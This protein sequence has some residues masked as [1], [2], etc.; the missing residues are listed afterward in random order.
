MARVKVTLITEVIDIGYGTQQQASVFHTEVVEEAVGNPLFI[1]RDAHRMAEQCA[2][3][4][5]AVMG[6]RTGEIDPK[7]RPSE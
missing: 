4:T 2:D 1:T 5:R 3:N 6:P 7:W